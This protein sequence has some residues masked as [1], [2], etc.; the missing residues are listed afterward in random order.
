MINE[1]IEKITKLQPSERNAVWGVGE[2]LKDIIRR[3]P[4]LAEIVSRD[5][6]LKGMSLV[7]CEQK[8]KARADKLHKGRSGSVCVTPMEAEGIIRKF[9]GLPEISGED[10][11]APLRSDQ[12]GGKAEVISLEEFF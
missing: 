3:E 1:T 7:D 5:L 10:S 2:Q 12:N 6:D 11:S 8:I 9:Y 4:A